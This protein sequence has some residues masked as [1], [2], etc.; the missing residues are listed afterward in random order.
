MKTKGIEEKEKQE[1]C[2]DWVHNY[3]ARNKSRFS[4]S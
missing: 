2:N 3:D 1:K 4:N